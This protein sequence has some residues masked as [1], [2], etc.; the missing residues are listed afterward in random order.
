MA[1]IFVN[2]LEFNPNGEPFYHMNKL[3]SYMMDREGEVQAFRRT[4]HNILD[5]GLQ[6]T[7]KQALDEL[8]VAIAAAEEEAKEEA[9][10]EAKKAE[11]RRERAAK[12][13]SKEAGQA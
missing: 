1:Q 6:P 9:T 13:A 12:K 3:E 2:W 7:R 10:K 11:G 8:L 4:I 5:W